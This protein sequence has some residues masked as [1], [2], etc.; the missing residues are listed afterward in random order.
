MPYSL[1]G[2]AAKKRPIKLLIIRVNMLAFFD[3]CV[4]L[5]CVGTFTYCAMM[6]VTHTNCAGHTFS[7]K[8]DSIYILALMEQVKY[9]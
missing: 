6:R 3:I 1:D 5:Q 4:C 9:I 8:Y 7:M 2:V